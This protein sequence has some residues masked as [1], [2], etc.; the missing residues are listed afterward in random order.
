MSLEVLFSRFYFF[1]LNLV[2][3]YS[4]YIC[5]IANYI[6]VCIYIYEGNVNPLQYFCLGNP[7]VRGIWQATVHGVTKSWTQLSY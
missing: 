7:M 2:V 1:L 5:Y 3:L 6:Y 4:I